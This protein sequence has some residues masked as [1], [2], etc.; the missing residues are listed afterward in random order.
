[1]IKE[2]LQAV[3]SRAAKNLLSQGYDS[4][5]EALFR[6]A[7]LLVAVV[8]LCQFDTGRYA[9]GPVIGITIVESVVTVVVRL[10]AK[11]NTPVPADVDAAGGCR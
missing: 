5:G 3:R 6:W 1:M 8:I 11:R 9:A 10:R 7:F 4:W 2:R